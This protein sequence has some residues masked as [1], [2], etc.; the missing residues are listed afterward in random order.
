MNWNRFIP[1]TLVL[2]GLCVYGDSFHGPLVFDDLSSIPDN[3]HI[4][5]L[6][7][8]SEWMHAPALS[9]VSGRPVVVFSLAVNYALG[10]LDVWGYH[11]FNL[12]VH[13]LNALLLFGIVRRTLMRLSDATRVREQAEWLALAISSIWLVHPLLTESVTY[14]IQRTELLMAL[15]FLLTLYCVI[16]GAD[17]ARSTGWYGAGVVCCALGMGCKEVMVSAPWVVL[18][19]DRIFL[20]RSMRA[21]AGQRGWL[22]AG[23]FLCWILL[24]ALVG[25]GD[26]P[27]SAGLG[28]R[29][30]APL[31]YLM[32]QC[33]V[34][35]RYLKLCFWPHPLVLDYGEWSAAPSFA[36]AAPFVAVVAVLGAATVWAF[37]RRSALAF[38]GAWFFLILAPTSSLVPVATE[39]AA[40]RRMYLPLAAVVSLV[41]IG[42]HAIPW[43]RWSRLTDGRVAGR[44]CGRGLWLAVMLLLG[45]IATARNRDYRTAISIWSDT[46]EKQPNNARAHNNLGIALAAEGNSDG[47]IAQYREALRLRPEFAEAWFNLGFALATQGRIAEAIERYEEALRFRPQYPAGHN[48][49]A[50]ALSSQG[51]VEEAISHYQEAIRLKPDFAEA[52]NNLGAELA[53]QGKI[54]EAIEHFSA[55]LRIRPSYQDARRNL[56]A[57]LAVQAK[58]ASPRGGRSTP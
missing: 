27:A 44:W 23:L 35:V 18:C 8:P 17:S 34:I 29:Y 20:A 41:V 32:T 16:R 56:D 11:A 58:E 38:L 15:F 26:R 13:I 37:L 4:R 45:S 5:R 57:A 43:R 47:A 51:R 19:Y 22:Y 49:L 7:P 55:A 6:W 42:V 50:L 40:E 53:G 39:V 36:S 21:I 46:V 31:P 48:N 25:L 33:G 12:G 3:P 28:V 54:R 9:S 1:L 14:I 10:G 24:A 52:E 30:S 2:A